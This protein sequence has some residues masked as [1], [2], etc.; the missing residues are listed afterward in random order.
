MISKGTLD[1]NTIAGSLLTDV[2]FMDEDHL[3]C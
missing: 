2:D 1:G 3:H